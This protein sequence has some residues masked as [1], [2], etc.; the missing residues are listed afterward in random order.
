MAQKSL[1][2]DF[3]ELYNLD[4]KLQNGFGHSVW[5]GEMLLM[6]L[7]IEA[8]ENED[9]QLK[10]D[11]VENGIRVEIFQIAY[12][13]ADFS[14]G[15]CGEDKIQGKFKKAKL[16]DRAVKINNNK[17]SPDS[18]TSFILFKVEIDNSVKRGNYPLMI[19]VKQKDKVKELGAEIQVINRKLPTLSSLD[20]KIDFWQ[21]P[22]SV[23]D[24]YN[25]RP[26]SEEHFRFLG[27]MFDQL[28]GINQRVVTTS[29]YWDLYNN[30]IRE[31]SQWMIQIRK[32]REG[33]FIYDYTNFERYVSL[34]FS[35]GV[36]RQI[37][38][39][40]LY[41]WNNNFFYYDEVTEKIVTNNALPNTPEH[42]AFWKPFLE[43][44]E[45]YLEDKGWLDKVMFYVDER[46]A[47][48]TIELARFIKRINQNYK[49]G[50]SGGFNSNLSPYI[51]DFSIP[52]NVT[53]SAD[54]L[55]TRKSAGQ[56]TTFYTSCYDR[57]PNMLITSSK[58]DIYYL[59]MLAKAKGFDGKLRWAFNQWSSRIME[60]AIYSHV[61][62]GD[63]H[64]V[65][66]HNQISLRY[67]LIKDGLEEV[68]KAQQRSSRQGTKRL[69]NR[70]LD[71]SLLHNQAGR[72]EL[73]ESMKKH[74][75]D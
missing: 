30:K 56:Q 21:F 6:M 70:F 16:P 31:S 72:I 54:V 63:A 65:Y 3:V 68:L 49:L 67:I 62:S 53:L 27:E 25:I 43:N 2:V 35:K 40:N 46:N 11:Q 47:K 8:D 45:V 19:E 36:D 26:W 15:F 42:Q 28:N 66:P 61:P 13:L 58:V 29:I 57:G 1:D 71:N 12:V 22:M 10:L 60:N 4:D 55:R 24:Y 44:F 18:T 20:F 64:F 50:Y 33:Q 23:A 17:I 52:S 34:A 69:L 48:I 5:R 74:L 51:Y 32:N 38:I 75:N 37:A 59:L 14:A 41:P 9:I 7:K 39:H 73:V